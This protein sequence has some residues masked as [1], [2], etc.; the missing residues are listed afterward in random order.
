MLAQRRRR[1]ANIGTALG[2]RVV[3]AGIVGGAAIGVNAC[4]I[5]YV[6]KRETD[7]MSG[8]QQGPSKHETFV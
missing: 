8:C 3:F 1:W 6:T 5:V 7:H 2:Q 4:V